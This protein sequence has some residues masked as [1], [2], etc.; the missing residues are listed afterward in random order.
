M[1]LQLIPPPGKRHVNITEAESR[2]IFVLVIAYSPDR[3][4]CFG[5]HPQLTVQIE[6]T[7]HVFLI[8]PFI[9]MFLVYCCR[10]MHA[11]LHIFTFS[12]GGESSKSRFALHI[13]LKFG[14]FLQYQ[15]IVNA[16]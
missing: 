5:I 4:T 7:V 9:S 2:N 8:N 1:K 14:F 12:R 16:T 13:F 10:N 15:Q 11:S 6:D 3:Q